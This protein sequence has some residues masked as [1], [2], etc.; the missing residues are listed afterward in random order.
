M[1]VSRVAQGKATDTSLSAA[2][3][4]GRVVPIHFICQAEGVGSFP[5]ARMEEA[6]WSE[7]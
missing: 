7:K 3:I 5:G 2:D 1:L 4:A 6:K